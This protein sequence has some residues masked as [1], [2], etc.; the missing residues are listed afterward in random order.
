MRD[1][2]LLEK[3]FKY[4]VQS[5]EL[6]CESFVEETK[7]VLLNETIRAMMSP[8]DSFEEVEGEVKTFK[9]MYSSNPGCFHEQ[10]IALNYPEVIMR[11]YIYMKS[12][13]LS[14]KLRKK[15]LSVV[16]ADNTKKIVI[17]SS[18]C[19]PE[20]LFGAVFD[21]IFAYSTD[22]DE[23]LDDKQTDYC[24]RK[25]V[26]D[27]NLIDSDMYTIVLNPDNLENVADLDC[28]EFVEDSF[29]EL[30]DQLKISFLSDS[31]QP[32]SEIR[33]MNRAIRKANSVNV[34]SRLSVL[35]ELNLKEEA[36]AVE[37]DRFVKFMG[38]LYGDLTKCL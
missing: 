2:K 18:I 11:T 38:D 29:E 28:T 34:M 21:E 33:C 22:E 3:N 27:N 32:K 15:Y 8:D 36:K 31:V 5:E 35:S 20:A 24:I 10:L 26:V 9:E 19:F 4:F 25:F 1:K 17:A 12:N 6:E 13:K 30:R 37:K 7:E 14:S 16:E 23:P